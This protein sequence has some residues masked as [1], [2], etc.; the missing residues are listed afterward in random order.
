MDTFF[1]S[2]LTLVISNLVTGLLGFVFSIILSRDLGP[3]GIGLYGI[4]MPVYDLFIC[5]I[6]GGMATSISKVGAVY[7]FKKDYSNLNRTIEASIFFDVVWGI[8]VASFVFVNSSFISG[9]MI[10]DSRAAGALRIICPAMVFIAVSSILKGYFYATS[11][12]KVPAFIDILEKTFRIGALLFLFQYATGVTAAYLV[13]ALGE[14]LSLFLLYCFYKFDKYNCSFSSNDEDKIQLVFDVLKYS[15]P[16]GINGFLST[17]FFSMSNLLLPRRL[18]MSGLDYAGAL[19]VM[20]K[21]SGMAITTALFPVMIVNALCIVLVPDISQNLSKKNYYKLEHRIGK[22]LRIALLLGLITSAVCMLF[23]NLLG[24]LLFNRN[25]LGSYIKFAALLPPFAFTAATTYGILNGLGK[26]NILLRNSL[27][28]SLLQLIITYV[29]SGISFI[30]I[31]GYG[32]ALII[33][34][35]IVLSLNLYEVGKHCSI[36][37]FYLR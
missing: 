19:S 17:I 20:G 11:N 22:V 14:G 34:N 10:N 15:F 4:V 30:N 29:L 9:Y 16:L 2:S 7:F 12:V 21:F 18:M 3:E 25:D 6:C 1:K 27:L 23:P 32:T 35:I 36:K 5:L 31:Y 8:I 13:L 33:T 37:V 26:Q 24:S 28:S